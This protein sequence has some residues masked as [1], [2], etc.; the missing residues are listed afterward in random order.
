MM[1]HTANNNFNDELRPYYFTP[2][3][4]VLNN[5]RYPNVVPPATV[6]DAEDLALADRI[7]DFVDSFLASPLANMLLT[8]EPTVANNPSTADAVSEQWLA[9]VMGNPLPKTPSLPIQPAKN[10][11]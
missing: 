1:T 9:V 5:T 6:L 8:I 10:P 3:A 7:E 4:P 11:S 2:E